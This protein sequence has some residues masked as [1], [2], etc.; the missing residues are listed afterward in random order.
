MKKTIIAIS[1]LL[2]VLLAQAKE[3]TIK[4]N[5]HGSNVKGKTEVFVDQTNETDS[6]IITPGTRISDIR[7]TIKNTLGAVISRYQLPVYGENT[8]DINT[9]DLPEG[10][11]IEV[12]DNTGIVYTNFE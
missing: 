6:I 7:V 4:V 10:C 3:R 11:L 1:T 12:E 5:S 2:V 9:P 8:I